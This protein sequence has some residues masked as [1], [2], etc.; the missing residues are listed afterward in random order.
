MPTANQLL[1]EAAQIAMALSI[2]Q[3]AI[4]LMAADPQRHRD[5][6]IK[7]SMTIHQRVTQALADAKE[8]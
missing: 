3:G 6:A 2:S 8:G 7:L 4:R 1:D 5:D